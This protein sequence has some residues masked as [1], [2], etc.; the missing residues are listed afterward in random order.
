VPSTGTSGCPGQPRVYS[1]LER[2]LT[3]H[4]GNSDSIWDLFLF[5]LAFRGEKQ[6][7][8]KIGKSQTLLCTVQMA[9]LAVV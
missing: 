2:I 1:T 5:C 4:T 6:T 3:Q 8:A 9:I 7:L